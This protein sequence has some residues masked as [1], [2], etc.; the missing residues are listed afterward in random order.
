MDFLVMTHVENYYGYQLK[1][2]E[3]QI[4]TANKEV[5]KHIS[6]RYLL[7]KYWVLVVP[8]IR[9]LVISCQNIW[10]HQYFNHFIPKYFAFYC[11]T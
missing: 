1:V 8:P 11:I 2:S 3:L 4:K 7:C 6:T 9:V 10:F 5:L